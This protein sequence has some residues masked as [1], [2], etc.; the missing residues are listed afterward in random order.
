MCR[1]VMI[2][3]IIFVVGLY[4]YEMVYV[5]SDIDISEFIG[6]TI[7]A[8]ITSYLLEKILTAP[9]KLQFKSAVKKGYPHL[10][11]EFSFKN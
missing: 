1:R 10:L 4:L 2:G 3:L 8:V 11:E 7:M 5:G 6:V 9:I